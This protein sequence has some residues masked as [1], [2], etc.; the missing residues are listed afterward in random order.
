MEIWKALCV[1]IES[2]IFFF[3]EIR[4]KIETEFHSFIFL[5]VLLN[6]LSLREQR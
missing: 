6:G 4:W 1:V 5:E 3:S 2:P